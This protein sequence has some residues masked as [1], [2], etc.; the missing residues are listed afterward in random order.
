MRNVHS[1]NGMGKYAFLL[2]APEL[3]PV[4]EHDTETGPSP[5]RNLGKVLDGVEGQRVLLRSD[6]YFEL[7]HIVTGEVL[8]NVEDPGRDMLDLMPEG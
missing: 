3:G 1:H 2:V 6:G 8:L 4:V 7:P 5:D